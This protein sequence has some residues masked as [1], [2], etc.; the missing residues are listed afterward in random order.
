MGCS[1]KPG[2]QRAWRRRAS[3]CEST[4]QGPG[5][6]PLLRE[7]LLKYDAL[8]D[9][10]LEGTTTQRTRSSSSWDPELSTAI[11]LHGARITGALGCMLQGA[12]QLDGEKWW[13]SERGAC[14]TRGWSRW[15]PREWMQ[16]HACSSAKTRIRGRSRF[17]SQILTPSSFILPGL[18][19]Q[20]SPRQALFNCNEDAVKWNLPGHTGIEVDWWGNGLK[21]GLNCQYAPLRTFH[22]AIDPSPPS[23]LKTRWILILGCVKSSL[24]ARQSLNRTRSLCEPDIAYICPEFEC[25]TAPL[26]LRLAGCLQNT[27]S[28]GD[29]R[30]PYCAILQ[31]L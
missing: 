3:G 12:M 19:I 31:M 9:V 25:C 13:W 7:W 30:K 20:G 28:S 16:S 1:W 26:C 5:T 24:D 23:F 4:G 15:M 22:Y 10:A 18:L 21:N 2:S 27:R 11:N 14:R 29:V 6:S 8:L 17:R